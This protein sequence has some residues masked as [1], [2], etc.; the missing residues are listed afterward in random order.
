[1]VEA[2]TLSHAALTWGPALRY[3]YAL[4]I[5][6]EGFDAL[7]ERAQ[8]QERYDL[9]LMST[10]GMTVTS[11]RRLVEALSEAG[12][13]ILVVHD[14]DKAGLEILH[15]FTASTRRY[16]YSI[17]PT[18]RDLGLRLDEAVA[19][20][21][22]SEPV[23]YDQTVDPRESL[24]ECGASSAECA[25]LVT[26]RRSDFKKGRHHVYWVGERI[27]LNAMTSQQFLDWLEAKLKAAG[28]GKVVPDEDVL[29]EA[30]QR[31]WSV[32]KLQKVINTSMAEPADDVSIP[33]DLAAQIR[34]RITDTAEAWD[35]ALWEIVHEQ[36][37]EGDTESA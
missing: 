4:F 25:F 8:I 20:G 2:P 26:E 13:T 33:D 19:L 32:A 31:Q 12:V 3:Q 30:F 1:M 9:A 28:V 10:K 34:E 22:E 18:V 7:L 35:D 37:D 16:H 21:L 23:L 14:F 6:K 24:R 29:A 15:K 5:E 17:P 11:A 36:Q 27:E